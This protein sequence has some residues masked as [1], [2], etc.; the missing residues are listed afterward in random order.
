MLSLSAVQSTPEPIE[1]LQNLFGGTVVKRVMPYR[2][3]L[4]VQ[5]QWQVSSKQAEQVL[6]M[7]Q[8]Y[9]IAKADE[10]ILALEFRS[11]FRPQYGDRSKNPPELDAKREAMMHDLQEMRKAKRRKHI[12]ECAAA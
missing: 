3:Q 11:T 4:K 12:P 8:P 5:F 7:M 2:G 10:A 1:F 6:R 9:L